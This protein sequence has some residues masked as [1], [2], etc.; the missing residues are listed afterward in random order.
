[1]KAIRTLLANVVDYAGLFPPARLDMGPTLANFARY[2]ASPDAW[3]LG[4]LVV[5]VARFEEF[6]RAAESLLPKVEGPTDDDAWGITALTAA[7]GDAAFAADIAAIERFN[8][9][10][11]ARGAGS[12]FVDCIEVKATT[13]DEIDR[14]I[15]LVPDEIYPY[16]EVPS[17][18]DPRG[19]IAAL[20]GL[21]A[22]AKIRTGGITS[23]AH[24]SI[25]EVALFL[26]ACARAEVPFKAT[27][28]LHHPMRHDARDVGCKQHGFLNVF[29]GGAL[30]HAGKIDQAE[31][32]TL[33]ADESV[34][35]LA[36]VDDSIAWRDRRLTIGEL[37][38]ARES[39]A[40]AFGSCSFEEPLA[41]LR[42]LRFLTLAP[43]GA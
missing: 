31:L 39:F 1:M 6:E 25:D 41:D 42:A 17:Q 36:V 13:A 8:E 23:D 33:L 24:P 10:H 28:G 37:R 21:D 9:R 3:M 34:A 2:R 11:A 27:A 35:S 18:R 19:C 15:D 4:R 14:A 16:F 38:H 29:L 12:A 20:A 40:H 32:A 26:I 30:A 22:G 43:A 5:P 7:A